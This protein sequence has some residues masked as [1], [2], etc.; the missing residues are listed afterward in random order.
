MAL[1]STQ[2]TPLAL[3]DAATTAPRVEDREVTVERSHYKHNINVQTQR[4]KGFEITKIYNAYLG[5]L[6]YEKHIFYAPL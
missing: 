6:L 1:I 3:C 4:D 2:R 5:Q